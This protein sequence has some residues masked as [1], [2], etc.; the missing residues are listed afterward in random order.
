MWNRKL[1]SIVVDNA[2]PI[3]WHGLSQHRG[4]TDGVID[5]MKS[6]ATQDGLDVHA[7]PVMVEC[8]SW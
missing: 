4:T 1:V 8:E 5:S 7:N 3:F 6:F 2:G